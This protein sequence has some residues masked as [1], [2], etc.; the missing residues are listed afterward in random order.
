[1]L[2]S[3]GPKT[4]IPASITSSL[5]V[6]C[7]SVQ[8]ALLSAALSNL[9]VLA[10]NIQN[11]YLTTPFR[12]KVFTVAEDKFGS[13]SGDSGKFMIITRA[14]Y[15]LNSAGASFCVFHGEHLQDMGYRP[16]L[17]DVWLRHALKIVLS[18][19]TNMF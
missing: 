1:M 9:D 14:L 2:V 4:E 12:E 11:T 15:G 13:D 7:N 3:G 19:T 8:I 16:C 6:S 18:S 5:V 17:A 10:C